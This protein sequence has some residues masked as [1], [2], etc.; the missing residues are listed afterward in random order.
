V[1][2]TALE[3]VEE[4]TGRKP[5]PRVLNRACTADWATEPL[6]KMEKPVAN[7]RTGQPTLPRPLQSRHVTDHGDPARDPRTR[8]RG[9][10]PG[11]PAA[12]SRAN[13]R[14]PHGLAG[15]SRAPRSCGLCGGVIPCG[16]A[17]PCGR[18]S[19]GCRVV[20]YARWVCPAPCVWRLPA[21]SVDLRRRVAPGRWVRL[22]VGPTWVRL[23]RG[24][25]TVA[26]VLTS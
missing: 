9:S 19:H 23:P 12:A 8:S 2:C 10:Q 22:W 24:V 11:Q 7:R 1:L 13:R 14:P 26:G 21:C 20:T 3:V 5:D 25:C 16:G 18:A 15:S 4:R 6:R 17:I